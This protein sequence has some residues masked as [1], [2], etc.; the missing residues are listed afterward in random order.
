[1]DVYVGLK[2]VALDNQ[3]IRRTKYGH[4]G[5]YRPTDYGIEWRTLS[6]FWI[7]DAHTTT[8]IGLGALRCGLLLEE[9]DRAQNLYREIP[10]DDVQHAINTENTTRAHDLLTYLTNDMGMEGLSE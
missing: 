9:T 4:A 1:M 3:P 8:Q 6:N 10:W 2:C 5:R 7:F